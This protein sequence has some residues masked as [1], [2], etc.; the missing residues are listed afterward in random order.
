MPAR[1]PRNHTFGMLYAI[2]NGV[3]EWAYQTGG[4]IV[5]SP[6]ICSDGGVIFSC[7]DSNVYKV[8]GCTTLAES[9]WPMFHHDPQHAGSLAGTNYPNPGCEAP[10]PNDGRLAPS[11]DFSF[12]CVGSPNTTWSVYASTNLTNWTKT[13]MSPL[14]RLASENSLI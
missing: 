14:I 2:S 12:S 13:G 6:V 1:P 4:D 3:Q 5:S 9:S 7:E 11:Y 8:A 10:F